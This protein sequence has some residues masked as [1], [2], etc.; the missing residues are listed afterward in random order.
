MNLI[1]KTLIWF[2]IFSL[3]WP[4]NQVFAIPASPTE[5]MNDILDDLGVDKEELKK[6]INNTLDV[7][8]LKKDPPSTTLLFIPENPI[9]GQEVKAIATP[10]NFNSNPDQM[11][12]TWF[13]K[14]KDSSGDIEDHKKEAM[15]I[16]ARGNTDEVYDYTTGDD[17]GDGYQ[18]SFG[19]DDQKGKPEHCYVHDVASGV[20]YETGEPGATSKDDPKMYCKHVFPESANGEKL[21]DGNFGLK[22]EKFWGTNP[23]SK[24]TNNDGISD[25]EALTG[26][27]MMEFTWIYEEGDEVGVAAEGIQESTDY[28]DSSYKTM[29]GLSNSTCEIE[30]PVVHP[31]NQ[32][33]RNVYKFERHSCE[34]P[35]R[36]SVRIECSEMEVPVIIPDFNNPVT[37]NGP[38]PNN[39]G[40]STDKFG[41]NCETAQLSFPLC[42]SIDPYGN[43][44]GRC[45]F[46][47]STFSLWKGGGENDSRLTIVLP[48]SYGDYTCDVCL[49]NKTA[50]TFYYPFD[51][52]DDGD[53]TDCEVVAEAG[54]E[55]ECGPFKGKLNWEELPRDSS[56]TDINECLKDNFIDPAQGTAD[57][58]IEVALSY[59]PEFPINDPRGQDESLE[60]N[61]DELRIK[62]DLTNV[63]DKS[64]VK[65]DWKFWLCDESGEDC[66]PQNNQD[67]ALPDG[68][69][70]EQLRTNLGLVKKSGLGLDSLNLKLQIGSGADLNFENNKYLKI[71]L[72]VIEATERTEGK[73]GKGTTLIPIQE[74]S[75][76]IVPKITEVTEAP[77][78]EAE[79][80]VNQIEGSAGNRY[81]DMFKSCPSRTCPAV[82]NEIIG[83]EFNGDTTDK[84]LAWFLNGKPMTASGNNS[85]K[86]Y[87]P[88][89]EGTGF[90][91]SVRLDISEI[92]A[93]EELTKEK[94]TLTRDFIVEDPSAFLAPFC[95]PEDTDCNMPSKVKLGT[96]IDPTEPTNLALQVEDFS[97]DLFQAE[98]ASNI[99]IAPNFNFD[100]EILRNNNNT[101]DQADDTWKIQWVV[102]G[103][104]V[105]P[106]DASPLPNIDPT[107]GN[108]NLPIQK[109]SGEKYVISAEALYNQ[110]EINKRA[111]H[112]IWN[113]PVNSFYAKKVSDSLEIEVIEARVTGHQSGTKKIL[114]SI[115]SGIPSYVNFLFRI[116]LAL[117]LILFL[118]NLSFIIFPKQN[119]Y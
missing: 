48:A 6:N 74:N 107:T 60:N 53:D 26:R 64:F 84:V 94:I 9:P 95:G 92:N 79:L 32:D 21:G 49:S 25:E 111:L 3:T 81:A 12:F 109:P 118:A 113:N 35:D 31:P 54:E 65:Y 47:L 106:Q 110:S 42:S 33:G 58:K 85:E 19:G 40:K 18:A 69:S 5:A 105:T 10:N 7:V 90:T 41:L 119:R 83:L 98:T 86:V 13:L 93:S 67:V 100:K 17:D 50:A 99:T 87:F 82:K 114:A 22:E 45:Y 27:G 78:T 24:D 73:S 112:K 14:R 117:A 2:F 108:L 4:S 72:R 8:N 77:N 70:L 37:H 91:Y 46:D 75:E 43:G 51:C 76:D 104:A 36:V 39:C 61:A 20:D 1:R 15:R 80:T 44:C 28:E 29:W 56:D 89:M 96:F 34:Y 59:S 55:F 115:F 88:I 63:E 116:I 68:M 57:K 103:I 71:D 30:P 11:Y 101:A 97:Q 102:D 16:L 52:F 66:F 62:A 38:T 23:H